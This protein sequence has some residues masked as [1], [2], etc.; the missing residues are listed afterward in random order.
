[1][2]SELN[3]GSRIDTSCASNAA[4][5]AADSADQ[6][7]SAALA[8]SPVW[9]YSCDHADHRDER[10]QHQRHQETDKKSPTRRGI[11]CRIGGT[12]DRPMTQVTHLTTSL[13]GT[14][15]LATSLLMGGAS[16]QAVSEH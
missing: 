3:S 5:I 2:K 16:A 12:D 7:A 9:Q 15:V 8:A 13:A 4:A 11:C 6:F 10:D 1:M 14:T